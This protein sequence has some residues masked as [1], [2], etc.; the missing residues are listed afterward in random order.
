MSNGPA[1]GGGGANKAKWRQLT[2]SLP[3]NCWYPL[4]HSLTTVLFS[5]E[6]FPGVHFSPGTFS[7]GTFFPEYFFSR[8]LFSPSTFFPPKNNDDDP[9][10]VTVVTLD[11]FSTLI[12]R[13]K[14]Q[15]LKND[16]FL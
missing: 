8:F 10:H 16:E 13:K 1:A 9:S 4:C 6:L 2:S 3:S 15:P 5:R 11:E 7:P 12:Y 14:T